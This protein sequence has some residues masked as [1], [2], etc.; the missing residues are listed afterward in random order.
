MLF[1]DTGRS[2]SEHL[3]ERRLQTAAAMLRD[4]AMQHLRIADIAAL[5]GFTD[6]SHF[7]RSFR[8]RY[9]DT[10]SGLRSRA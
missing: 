8:R 7:N 4:P 2:L 1:E 9:G 10:P 3:M 6:L 5:A